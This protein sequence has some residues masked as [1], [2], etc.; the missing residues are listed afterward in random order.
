MGPPTV[1]V[2]AP[3]IAST[4]GAR[5]AK[6]G[7]ST[8]CPISTGP[9]PGKDTLACTSSPVSPRA[10]P[11]RSSFLFLRDLSSTANGGVR[12]VLTGPPPTISDSTDPTS[13][14]RSCWSAPGSRP[15]ASCGGTATRR[16]ALGS[17]RPGPS[18]PS[19][20]PRATTTSGTEPP[21]NSNSMTAPSTLATGKWTSTSENPWTKCPTHTLSS[22]G[23]RPG[24]PSPI[25]GISTRERRS[26]IPLTT[27]SSK[28]LAKTSTRQ[29][30]GP[31]LLGSRSPHH[32]HHLLPWP[33]S[34][35][36]EQKPRCYYSY[37]SFTSL[38]SGFYSQS[39]VVSNLEGSFTLKMFRFPLSFLS[40]FPITLLLYLFCIELS[41]II[42]IILIS[43]VLYFALISMI[44]KRKK[45]FFEN[46]IKNFRR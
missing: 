41:P 35:E 24:I 37:F 14:R 5:E 4:T 8:A 30:S 11:T 15:A 17:S 32:H 43:I 7:A 12:M 36:W 20:F 23:P 31:P 10:L 2:T 28:D 42:C 29:S 45:V 39:S 40:H 16:R 27:R 18:T 6:A 9:S 3:D 21:S 33:T 1:T 13:P 26:N 38:Q 46:G 25:T 44:F 34:G 22:F 19:L